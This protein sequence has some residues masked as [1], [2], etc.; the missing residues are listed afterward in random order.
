MTC[1]V[2]DKRFSMLFCHNAF[3]C[4]YRSILNRSASA[5][6]IPV[7]KAYRFIQLKIGLTPFFDSFGAVTSK[8][9]KSLFTRRFT[10][11]FFDLFV[12]KIKNLLIH[13]LYRPCFLE[14][15]LLNLVLCSL[16]STSLGRLR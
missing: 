3:S 11:I 10:K 12:K 1:S 2:P 6:V 4:L 16:D 15:I 9:S 8:L 14:Q 5:V 7:P 13:L